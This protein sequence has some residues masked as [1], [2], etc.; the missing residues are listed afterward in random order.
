MKQE[1][2]C[3]L[4]I[5]TPYYLENNLDFFFFWANKRL[6]NIMIHLE[7]VT[8]LQAYANLSFYE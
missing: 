4:N 1:N 7:Y 6:D 3:I 5:F 8:L 2:V